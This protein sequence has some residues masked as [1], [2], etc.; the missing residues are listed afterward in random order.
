[1]GKWE[2]RR[3]EIQRMV[4]AGKPDEHIGVVYGVTKSSIYQVRLRLK[5]KRPAVKKSSYL[6]KAPQPELLPGEPYLDP[7]LGVMV[8]PYPARYAAGADV[9]VVTARP[10]R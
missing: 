1:V 10:R 2:S 6:V 9:Q 3:E 7:E 5:I 4:D 8:T